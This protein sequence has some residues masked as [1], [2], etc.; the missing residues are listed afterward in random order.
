[1]REHA[2]MTLEDAAGRLE[3]TRSSL[4]RIEQGQTKAD[5]HLVKSM[6]DL[7]D[8]YDEELAE[9][10]RQAAKSGWWR[11][12]GLKDLGYVDVETEASA[13]LEFGGLNIPGLLQ[14]EAYTRALFRTGRRRTDAELRND[15][16]V[17]TIRQQRLTDE[18]RPLELTAIVDQAALAREVGGREVMHAQLR[19]LA[20]VS[21]LP[22]LTLQVLPFHSGAH[23]SMNGAFTVLEFPEKDELDLLYVAYPTGA[24]HLEAEAEVR[25]ARL[26]FDRLRSQALSPHD[27]A[28]FIGRMAA[29]LYGSP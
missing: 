15:V 8:V 21:E 9:L 14:T 20:E 27:S 17:R 12:Y 24:V 18:V 28:A 7:Y 29:E 22:R 19:R 23:D 3:K 6:M 1:M 16:A 4:H 5:I 2:R 26:V 11:A 13:V 25:A 10:V